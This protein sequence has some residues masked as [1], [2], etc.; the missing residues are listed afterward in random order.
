MAALAA[1]FLFVLVDILG[2]SIVLPLLPY[3]ST[4]FNLTP[5]QV[6]TLQVCIS[7]KI[8]SDTSQITHRSAESPDYIFCIFAPLKNQGLARLNTS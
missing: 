6:G 8:S 2:F 1:L 5:Y 4:A 7:A 3:L